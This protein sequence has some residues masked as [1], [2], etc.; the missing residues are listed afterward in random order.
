MWWMLRLGTLALY[1]IVRHNLCTADVQLMFSM[2]GKLMKE[3]A[4]WQ[5]IWLAHLH[6]GVERFIDHGHQHSVD[7]EA[8]PILRPNHSLS[9]VLC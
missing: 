4:L 9:Q 3:V 1:D 6:Q 8:W 2:F 7:D 5:I